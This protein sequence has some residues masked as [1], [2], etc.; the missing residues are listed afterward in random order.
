MDAKLEQLRAEYMERS[1]MPG[2]GVVTIN[3]QNIVIDWDR[4]GG[5]LALDGWAMARV[6]ESLGLP[7]INHFELMNGLS[8]EQKQEWYDREQEYQLWEAQKNYDTWVDNKINPPLCPICETPKDELSGN[9][10]YGVHTACAV[11]AVNK[12]IESK[13]VV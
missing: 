8:E 5:R 7:D 2:C 11:Y 1:K 9:G 4:R 6:S 10:F 12:M 3:E 13:K